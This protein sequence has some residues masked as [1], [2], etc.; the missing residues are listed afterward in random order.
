[1]ATALAEPYAG[2]CHCG[3]GSL[4]QLASGAV[5]DLPYAV[6]RRGDREVELPAG[7]CRLLSILAGS[8]RQPQADLAERYYGS[9][10]LAD[11][12]A[13]RT[14]INRLRHKLEPIGA[15]QDLLTTPGGYLLVMARPAA[16]RERSRG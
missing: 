6:V 1:M 15:D 16:P 10:D 8:G 5:V 12:R 9:R 3:M 13:L 2:A 14:R 4:I 11:V 7:Q